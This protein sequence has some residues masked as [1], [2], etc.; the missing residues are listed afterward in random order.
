MQPKRNRMTK[1]RCSLHPMVD[2]MKCNRSE[3][4]WQSASPELWTQVL[5]I[6]KNHK[7]PWINLMVW[8][9]ASAAAADCAIELPVVCS[10]ICSVMCALWPVQ[11]WHQ[12]LPLVLLYTHQLWWKLCGGFRGRWDPIK[13]RMK[14]YTKHRQKTYFVISLYYP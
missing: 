10:F 12:F 11:L 13:Q 3:T 2:K 4:E 7:T 6:E 14:S 8:L 5:Q 9:S 1:T